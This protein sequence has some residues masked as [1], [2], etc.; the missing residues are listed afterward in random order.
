MSSRRPSAPGRRQGAG[1]TVS[2]PVMP[3]EWQ[4]SARGAA[5]P[6][7]S[8]RRSWPL[9][10]GQGGVDVEGE[11]ERIQDTGRADAG[12]LPA[13]AAGDDVVDHR[14]V[15][16]TGGEVDLALA[17]LGVLGQRAG[18]AAVVASGPAALD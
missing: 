4:E 10:C 12:A 8:P 14:G 18:G 5:S 6:L 17:L 15:G 1:L 9:G 11:L 3:R 16:V 13:L 7:G 2:R